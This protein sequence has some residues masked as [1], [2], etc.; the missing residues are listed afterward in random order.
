MI[1]YTLTQCWGFFNHS[2]DDDDDAKK[3]IPATIPWS[4]F[5]FAP[6]LL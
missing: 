6:W 4:I 5:Q 2:D 3:N 1:V